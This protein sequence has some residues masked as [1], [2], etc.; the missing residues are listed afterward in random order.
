METRARNPEIWRSPKRRCGVPRKY[1]ADPQKT[2]RLMELNRKNRENLLGRRGGGEKIYTF[3]THL[4]SSVGTLQTGT[5]SWEVNCVY[6]SLY[7]LNLLSSLLLV[8]E[9]HL[10]YLPQYHSDFQIAPATSLIAVLFLRVETLLNT[11]SAYSL[12]IF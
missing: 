10:Q 9:T 8:L 7:Y 5:E 2:P 12:I 3:R 4:K 6:P 11:R 1:I